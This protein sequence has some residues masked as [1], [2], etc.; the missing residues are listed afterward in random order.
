MMYD[1]L[2]FRNMYLTW[3]NKNTLDYAKY[4][5][6]CYFAKDINKLHKAFLKILYKP[7]R[8]TW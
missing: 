8:L 6:L 5:E 2:N 4:I 3:F 7:S 1:K